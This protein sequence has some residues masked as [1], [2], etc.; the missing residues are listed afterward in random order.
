MHLRKPTVSPTLW[1]VAAQRSS[2]SSRFGCEEATLEEAR[3]ATSPLRNIRRNHDL[4]SLRGRLWWIVTVLPCW[5]LLDTRWNVQKDIEDVMQ[6]ALLGVVPNLDKWNRRRKIPTLEIAQKIRFGKKSRRILQCLRT[7]IQLVG[8]T[9]ISVTSVKP[10]EGKST[11]STNIVTFARAGYK[12]LLIVIANSVCQV[13]LNHRK[14]YR[15]C[16]AQQTYHRFMWN[17]CWK[18]VCH[19]SGFCITK[20]LCSWKF[21][22][23]IDTLRRNA[24]YIVVDTAPIGVVIDAA[25]ITEMWPSVLVT[26]AG[27]NKSSWCPK[28]WK[29]NSD[30][31]TIL[32]IVLNKLNKLI[33]KN[34]APMV[35]GNMRYGKN[36]K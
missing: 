7:N 35:Y 30:R 10:G 32:R 19:S 20:Q 26:A 1:E 2:A 14:D 18:F 5:E 28:S 13:S 17:Q 31:Q 34:M 21:A 15:F 23:M 29:N 9:V 27:G 25:I 16:Q 33:E 36:N 22:T 4:D 11:T 6:I 3:P 12:T 24:D 8:I